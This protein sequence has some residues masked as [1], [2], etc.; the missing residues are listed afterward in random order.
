M[1]TLKQADM[2]FLLQACQVLK[3]TQLDETI[4]PNLEMTSGTD[5]FSKTEATCRYLA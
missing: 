3:Q 5:I 4:I 2:G 1:T